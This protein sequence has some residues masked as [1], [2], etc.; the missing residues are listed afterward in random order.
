MLTAMR[1]VALGMTGALFL[2][3]CS[4]S[5]SADSA[6]PMSEEAGG[7]APEAPADADGGVTTGGDDAA[8]ESGAPGLNLSSTDRSVIT[9]GS[10][11]MTVEDPEAAVRELSRLVEG[12]G[13][14][15][16]GLHLQ[17]ATEHTDASA[18]MVLRIP[19]REVSSTLDRLDGLGTVEDVNLNRSDVTMQV[20]DLEARIR[21]L[22]LSI[23][24]MEALLARAT[25]TN[26]LVNAEQMLTER[27]TQLESLL[28]QQAL[29]ADQVSMSTLEVQLWV[30]DA[31]PEPEP[32]PPSGFWGG[33]VTGWN[34]F[35]A[36]GEDALLVLGILVPW[37]VF[38]ALVTLAVVAISR[39]LRRRQAAT[40]LPAVQGPPS[41]LPPQPWPAQQQQPVQAPPP[42]PQPPGEQPEGVPRPP[43]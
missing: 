38:L 37:L 25:T 34:A 11:A 43:A 22:K 24:R 15:V 32:E 13:G 14:W 36:F 12:M 42:V 30:P 10:V 41:G 6:A 35:L 28:S 7:S 20:R 17:A 16:E 21:A 2:A 33:L 26:D 19:S 4:S 39:P 23:E 29:L 8:A 27:Q 9:T 18:S 31:L 1:F 40:A 5:G 3:G